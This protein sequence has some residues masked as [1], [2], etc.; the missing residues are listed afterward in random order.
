VVHR[1][2]P[3]AADYAALERAWKEGRLHGLVLALGDAVRDRSLP[4]LLWAGFRGAFVYLEPESWTELESA[5]PQIPRSLGS[6]LIVV[7]P[8]LLPRPEGQAEAE[9][10]VPQEVLASAIEQLPALYVVLSAEAA[11][12]AEALCA[13]SPTHVLI[14]GEAD[15]GELPVDGRLVEESAENLRYLTERT[16][17]IRL[18]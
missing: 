8:S 5:A 10:E 2:D 12:A 3:A 14:A 13:R 4:L 17:L 11:E 1:P 9:L 16:T 15:P 18:R 6:P 7:D